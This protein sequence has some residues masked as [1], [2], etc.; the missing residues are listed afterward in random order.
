MNTLP[1]IETMAKT[2]SQLLLEEIGIDDLREV[3]KINRADSD[4]YT[5]ASHS[6]CDANMVM[7]AAFIEL[8]GKSRAEDIENNQWLDLWNAAWSEAKENDFYIN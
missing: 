1:T 7:D 2:F 8:T 5:C 6:Y 4:P 3:V